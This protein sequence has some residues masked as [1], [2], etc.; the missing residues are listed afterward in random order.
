MIV[1]THDLSILYQI[2]DTILVMYAGRLAEKGPAETIVEPPLHPY[3]RLLIGSLPEV[4]VR[5]DEQRLAG[6]PRPAAVAPRPAERLPLPAPLPARVRQVRRAAAVR[7]GRARPPR[8]LLG[9]GAA[10][11]L[12]LDRVSKSYRVG[13]FGGTEL[14]RGPRRQLRDRARRDRLAD[15]RE[16][17]RQ[18]HDRPD[19][20]AAHRRR[21]SGAIAFDGTDIAR[22]KGAGC[23]TTTG[24]CR[25]CSRIRSAPTTR[26]SR[27]TACSR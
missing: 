22:L 24:T 2:A 12:A 13:T 11:M 15:R 6:H 17:Q 14:A 19:D 21:P 4:G 20:P 7:R 18:E 3:T 9:D 23:R 26:S 27:P 16:R 25:A 5:H 8:R 1:I 10:V